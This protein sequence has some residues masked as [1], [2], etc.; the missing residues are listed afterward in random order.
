MT[1]LMFT[2]R[3][4]NGQ[5]AILRILVACGACLEMT[6]NNKNTVLHHA[7]RDGHV[8]SVRFLVGE[9]APLFAVN[10]AKETPKQYATSCKEGRWKEVVALLEESEA[11]EQLHMDALLEAAEAAAMRGSQHL[12]EIDQSKLLAK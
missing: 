10:K 2:A 9:G 5:D 1:A 8:A 12:Q 11:A 6:D 4:Y 3:Y 7:A